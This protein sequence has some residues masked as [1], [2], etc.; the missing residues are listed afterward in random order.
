MSSGALSWTVS[1]V[2]CGP[3][4]AAVVVDLLLV[5]VVSALAAL[6]GLRVVVVCGSC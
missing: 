5:A 3:S 4:F 2:W 6:V 1:V